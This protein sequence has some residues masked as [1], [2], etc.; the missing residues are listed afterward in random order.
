MNICGTVRRPV[1]WTSSARSS[2]SSPTSISS[3]G[4]PRAARSRFARTQNGQLGV[5]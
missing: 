3:K 5:E 1:R 2:A 4:M